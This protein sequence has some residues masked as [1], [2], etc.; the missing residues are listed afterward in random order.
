MI[1]GE[2]DN[3]FLFEFEFIVPA[4]QKCLFRHN[5]CRRSLTPAGK[6][7]LFTHFWSDQR[8]SWPKVKYLKTSKY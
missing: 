7:P 6:L 4:V 5:S 2:Q 8:F 1:L 3:A